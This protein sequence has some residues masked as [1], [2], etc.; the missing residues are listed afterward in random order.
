MNKYFNFKNTYSQLPEIMFQRINPT[1][2]ASPSMLIYN[3]DYA[4]EIGVFQGASEEEIVEILSGNKVVG[5]C[6]A[7][8]Y[9][10]HQFGFFNVLG[11]GRAVLLGEHITDDKRRL[12]IQLKGSGRTAFSRNGDGRAGVGPMLREYLISEAMYALGIKTTRSL[13][14]VSS[15]EKVMRDEPL[16][17]AILTRVASSH[18]RVGTFQFATIEKDERLTKTL[19]DYSIARH[20][21]EFRDNYLAFFAAVMDR[22]I[23]LVI[24][25]MRVGF[26]HGVM[27][28]DNVSLCGE[29]IDYGPCAFMD[30]YNPMTVFSSIDHTGRYAY[31]NQPPITGWNMERFAETIVP[32]ISKNQQEAINL[33][34]DRLKL[35]M[36][37]Y[38]TKYAKMISKKLGYENLE[39][40]DGELINSLLE[41][42]QEEE[43]D[44]TNTFLYLRSLIKPLKVDADSLLGKDVNKSERFDD[45]CE[46]WLAS[47]EKKG[48][49]KDRT[50]KIMEA[51]NPIVIPRN[52]L[53]DEALKEA[54]NGDLTKFHAL[55][56]VLKNPYDY[57]FADIDY[58]MPSKNRLFITYCGT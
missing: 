21:P 22:Q 31:A 44:Y 40:D 50:L 8:A 35:F 54:E 17:G 38:Q 37:H 52:H 56:K 45:F 24:D 26:V 42:M 41:V 28:T 29:T 3:E 11:D 14:V 7:Q 2:V 1:P 13:A 55:L 23:N 48:Q 34:R 43:M 10:G 58:M 12:D 30:R 6:I 27:N 32:L 15:G 36:P 47:L 5:D 16:D 18:I 46:K 51:S 53:V 39:P 9:G 49:D 20:Y 25:W 57:S 19:A 4:R 33:L